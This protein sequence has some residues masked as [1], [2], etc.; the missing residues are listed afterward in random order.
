[1]PTSFTSSYLVPA[2]FLNPIVILHAINTYAS[3]YIPSAMRAFPS[4]SLY[5]GFEMLGPPGNQAP[6][7]DMHQ[8]NVLCL[9]YTALMVVVQVL[10]Y[11]KVC[12]NREL[13]KLAKKAKR[14]QKLRLAAAEKARLAENINIV[15]AIPIAPQYSALKTNGKADGRAI[16][17]RSGN[18]TPE[19]SVGSASPVMALDDGL[20]DFSD[21]TDT[22]EEETII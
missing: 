17:D 21:L 1:M 10:A 8:D 9:K 18:I 11:A 12:D 20:S 3:H 22:S 19:T 5:K 2:V 4:K 16:V 6:Y 7:L 13:R 15:E 14:E